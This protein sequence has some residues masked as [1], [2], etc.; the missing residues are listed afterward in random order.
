[1]NFFSSSTFCA[2]RCLSLEGKICLVGRRPYVKLPPQPQWMRR[3]GPLREKRADLHAANR[4]AM[5]TRRTL[6]AMYPI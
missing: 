6:P 4:A 5:R 3:S 2:A 1:M